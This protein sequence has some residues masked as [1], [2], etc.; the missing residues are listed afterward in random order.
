[1]PGIAL[2]LSRQV[3][4]LLKTS[5]TPKPTIATATSATIVVTRVGPQLRPCL[6]L[7]GAIG[8]RP[9]PLPPLFVGEDAG[10]FFAGVA[11]FAPAAGRVDG[12]RLPPVCGLLML[13]PD[14]RC[15]AVRHEA[16]WRCNSDS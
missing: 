14:P 12:R 1:M 2:A 5:Y 9:P 6:T 11:F 16:Q 4:L 8:G 13:M 15:A 7:T 3:S 10:A